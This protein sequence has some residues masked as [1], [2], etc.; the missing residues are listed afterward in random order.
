MRPSFARSL[1]SR[2]G[3]GCS[4][5]CGAQMRLQVALETAISPLTASPVGP[6]HIYLALV[7]TR[8]SETPQ[9]CH[10]PACF[11][12]EVVLRRWYG[13]YSCAATT[14]SG[15][16]YGSAFIAPPSSGMPLAWVPQMSSG[17]A[18]CDGSASIIAAQAVEMAAASTATHTGTSNRRAYNGFVFGGPDQWSSPSY[19]YDSP[20]AAASLEALAA[21]GA[22]TAEIIVQVSGRRLA[23]FAS[24]KKES[25]ELRL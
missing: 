20:G 24:A 23:D 2:G 6:T 13:N 11:P 19:R 3:A 25:G 21:T 8:Y 7:L 10:M 5:G 15:R 17:D 22:D 4:G 14:E 16:G 12:A 1:G 9:F 18:L